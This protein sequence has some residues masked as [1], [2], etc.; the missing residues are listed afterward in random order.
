M[1]L[2]IIQKTSF[3]QETGAKPLREA[4]C[5]ASQSPCPHVRRPW[6]WSPAPPRAHCDPTHPATPAPPQCV[7]SIRCSHAAGGAGALQAAQSARA[8]G[9]DWFPVGWAGS[10]APARCTGHRLQA[11]GRPWHLIEAS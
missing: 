5:L 3:V 2:P 6:Q 7:E 4:L 8:R 1:A 9:D 11:T 10:E